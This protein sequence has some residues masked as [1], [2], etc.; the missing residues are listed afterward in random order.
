MGLFNINQ[1]SVTEIR[2]TLSQVDGITPEIAG[3][4]ADYYSEDG[5]FRTATEFADKLIEFGVEPS[6]AAQLSTVIDVGPPALVRP[7]LPLRDR[8]VDFA[9]VLADTRFDLGGFGTPDD[10]GLGGEKPGDGGEDPP[11]EPVEPGNEPVRPRGEPVLIVGTPKLLAFVPGIL[12]SE[13]KVTDNK[14]TPNAV[15]RI[16]FP[17]FNAANGEFSSIEDLY[18]NLELGRLEPSGALTLDAYNVIIMRLR[19]IGYSVDRGNLLVFP[20]NWTQSNRKSGMAFAERIGEFLKQYKDRT[21]VTVEKI[22]VICHSMGGLVTR[23][24][25]NLFNAPIDKVVYIGTP[26]FGA[27]KAYVTL[28]PDLS[29][30]LTGFLA[31]AAF[32]IFRV[33]KGLKGG[34]ERFADLAEAL[35]KL[36]RQCASVYELLPDQ[37]YLKAVRMLTELDEVF[38]IPDQSLEQAKLLSAIADALGII[39]DDGKSPVPKI[40]RSFVKRTD[41]FDFDEAYFRGLAAFP[42]GQQLMVGEGLQFKT[43]LGPEIPNKGN[44]LLII[45]ALETTIDQ[46]EFDVTNPERSVVRASRQRGDGTVPTFSASGLMPTF[47]AG[48]PTVQ[49]DAVHAQLPN[50]PKAFLAI[51]KFL[52]I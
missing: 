14:G 2:S 45:N 52:G 22:D 26:H 25:T 30:N 18:R 47:N 38:P 48:G 8:S 6:K 12:G 31:E 3:R 39:D 27:V 13:L 40:L 15:S 1:L 37:E 4:L 17:P 11:D 34:K 46:V 7:T 35:N 19:E 36:A 51:R 9:R 41:V 33:Y 44:Y 32:D 16:V 28:H 42:V 20:Y 29:G 24:A 21:G 10:G 23:A 50:H 5:Q 49:I 43:D